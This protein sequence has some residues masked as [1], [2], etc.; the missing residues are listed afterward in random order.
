LATGSAAV[1]WKIKDSS[2]LGDQSMDPSAREWRTEQPLRARDVVLCRTPRPRLAPFGPE[3]NC[4]PA[5]RLGRSS[6]QQPCIAGQRNLITIRGFAQVL[7]VY[8]EILNF[9]LWLDREDNWT[10]LREAKH[11]SRGPLLAIQ[12]MLFG[13]LCECAIW[14]FIGS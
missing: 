8:E 2:L 9:Q 14:L 11:T 12:Q 7:T 3:S 6:K 10:W 1:P 4:L 13:L 5:S